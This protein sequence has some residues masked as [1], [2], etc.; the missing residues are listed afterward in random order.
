MTRRRLPGPRADLR[1]AVAV[2]TSKSLTNR[3][4]VAAAAAGGG[5]VERPLDCE[6]TRLLAEALA[7]AGWWVEWSGA[8]EVGARRPLA[9]AAV[10]LGNSGTGSRLLLGLFAC[11]PGSFRVDGSPR[12]RERPMSPL[13]GALGDLGAKLDSDHGRLPVTVEGRRLAGGAVRIRPGA[14]SQFVSSL[15]MAAPLMERGLELEV[16]GPVPSRPYLDLTAEVLQAFGARV[17]NEGGRRWLVA[18]G[19]LGPT[20]YRVEGDWSAAAFAAAAAAVAGGT[21][22]VSPLSPASRQGDRAICRFLERAGVATAPSGDGLRVSGRIA[23]PFEAD[24]VDTPDLFPALAVVAAAGPE[25]SVLR[26]LDHLGHKE[27][28]RLAVMVANLRRLGAEL[29]VGPSSLRTLRRLRPLAG[30]GTE[31][32]AASDH[33]IAMAMAVAALVVGPL[34]LDDDACVA[35]SFPRFWEMWD[36]LLDGASAPP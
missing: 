2:P 33:R 21:V 7:A 19:G 36:T 28:D 12:L 23:R 6:D 10:D 4:I 35:K 22:T 29:E 15:L 20:S 24:L 25:G 9:R 34:E 26:G 18:P 8:I 13:L 17:G 16:V 30:G 1:S 3:A 11:V 5:R 14:S 31:V 27:S 32:T